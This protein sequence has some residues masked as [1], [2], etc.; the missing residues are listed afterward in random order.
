MNILLALIAGYCIHDAL[1]PTPVGQVLDKLALPADL[2]V[3]NEIVK[4]QGE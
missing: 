4:V 3:A 1:Q 2:F